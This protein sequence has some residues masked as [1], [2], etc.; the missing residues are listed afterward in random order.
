MTESK[1]SRPKEAKNKRYM[2]VRYGR[3]ENIGWFEHYQTTIDKVNPKVIVKTDRGL[4]IGEIVGP[5]CY[6]AGNFKFNAEQVNQYYTDSEIENPCRTGGKFLR[7][8]T[9][10]DIDEKRH[11][12]KIAREELE[13]CRELVKTK[14]LDMEVVDIEHVFGGERII[15]YFLAEGRIDFRELVKEIAQQY[16]TRIEM[17]QIGSRDE[18][19]LFGDVETCGRECCCKRFLKLLKPVNMRMAKLQKATLDPAKISGYCGRLK[20][21]LRYEDKTYTELKK[22]MP[23]KDTIVKTEQGSGKVIG[24]QILT[25]LVMIETEEGSRIG[26]PIDEIDIIST[27]QRKKKKQSSPKQNGNNNQSDNEKEK[28]EQNED[29]QD[30]AAEEENDS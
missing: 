10:E 27:P 5:A 2:L 25:Q 21:C 26:V 16:Q 6:K 4:E 28:D 13:F 1:I 22:K 23:R 15:F 14:E 9:N 17:R 20:C 19:K 30:G 29:K 3:M 7:Y 12:D 8:A 24:G 18:A 11:L